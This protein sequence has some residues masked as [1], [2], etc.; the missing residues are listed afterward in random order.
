MLIRSFK[1]RVRKNQTDLLV[2]NQ[3]SHFQVGRRGIV[4]QR[5]LALRD[6][7]KVGGQQSS[8]GRLAAGALLHADRRE[9]RGVAGEDG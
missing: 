6:P 3:L 4:Q 8:G 7:Q 2:E 1:L 9:V 5:D